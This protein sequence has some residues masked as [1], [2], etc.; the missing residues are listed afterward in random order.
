MLEKKNLNSEKLVN[1]GKSF[2]SKSMPI[3]I[4]ELITDIINQIKKNEKNFELGKI[5]DQ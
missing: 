2:I 5:N 3:E 4:M 1:T